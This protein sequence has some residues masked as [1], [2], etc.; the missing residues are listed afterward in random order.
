MCWKKTLMEGPG[1]DPRW[2]LPRETPEMF[3]LGDAT[4]ETLT[5]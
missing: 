4:D 1:V 3:F 2:S 5:S